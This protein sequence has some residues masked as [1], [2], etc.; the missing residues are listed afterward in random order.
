MPDLPCRDRWLLK[1]T[2][3]CAVL[4]LILCAL[5]GFFGPVH[6]DIY[7]YVD[8]NGVTHFTNV[9]TSPKYSLYIKDNFFVEERE[10]LGDIFGLDPNLPNRYDLYIKEAAKRYGVSFPLI[11]AIIKVESAF[12]PKAVSPKGAMGL[13]QLMPAN[14]DLLRIKNPFDP[15]E[16]IMGGTRFFKGLLNRFNGRLSYALAGY[17]AGPHRVL[18]YDGIPP[19]KETQNYVKKV[20]RYYRMLENSGI[21]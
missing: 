8:E 16:N 19:Y 4:L 7:K 9:P 1:R 12:N 13:M 15:W 14:V 2:Q 20:L 6:A 10:D 21:N 3:S 18:Q 5:F 11:K 17:N